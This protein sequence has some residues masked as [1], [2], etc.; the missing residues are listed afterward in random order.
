MSILVALALQPI[1][2]TQKRVFIGHE[3]LARFFLNGEPTGPL[4]FITTAAGWSKLDMEVGIQLTRWVSARRTLLSTPVFLNVSSATLACDHAFTQWLEIIKP[5]CRRDGPALFIEVSENTADCVLDRRWD[6]LQAHCKGL[7]MDD[8]GRRQATVDRLH[9]FPWHFGKFASLADAVD[10]VEQVDTAR[11]SS[12][13][14]VEC[15]ETSGG[16]HAALQMGLPL[17]QGYFFA[18]PRVLQSR[19]TVLS[20]D[21]KGTATDSFSGVCQRIDKGILMAYGG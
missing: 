20:A 1:I 14:I 8:I 16:S 6:A 18:R 21:I 3:V 5:L 17:Q 2:D 7:A 10:L 19:I 15:I 4:Q 12:R 13:L 9:H 11:C